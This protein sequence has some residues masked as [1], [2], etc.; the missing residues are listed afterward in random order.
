MELQ[1]KMARRSDDEA[2]IDELLEKLSQE[3]LQSDNR[4]T[5]SFI[6]SRYNAGQGPVKIRYELRQRGVQSELIDEALA[7][8]TYD[9]YQRAKEVRLK[10]F[11]SIPPSNIKDK[12]KQFRFLNSRGFDADM[13]QYACEQ[14]DEEHN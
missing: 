13:I 3:G 9:W 7:K 11:A 14:S 4:F 8:E 10:K 5:E 12:A 6:R 2:M 1:H